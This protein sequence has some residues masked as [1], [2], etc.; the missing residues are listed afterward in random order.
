MIREHHFPQ[1]RAGHRRPG[2]TSNHAARLDDLATHLMRVQRLW[3]DP[4]R[5]CHLDAVLGS[6]R[7]VWHDI[8]TALAHGTLSLP[9]EVRENL[10]ILSV[11]AHSK[12]E[13]CAAKPDSQ[14]LGSLIALTR[15]LA[16]SLKEWRAAA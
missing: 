1:A 7:E 4:D 14:I 5:S 9:L 11:Y 6:S 12:I 13:T 8:Q 16:G 15:T 10:L 3:D 2:S